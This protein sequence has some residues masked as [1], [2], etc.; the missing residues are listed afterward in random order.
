MQRIPT[1]ALYRLGA[2][3]VSQTP[4]EHSEQ[5]PEQQRCMQHTLH[6]RL[7]RDHLY[8]RDTEQARVAHSAPLRPPAS[9]SRARDRA[10]IAKP[11]AS[12]AATQ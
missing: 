2:E 3:S 12:A 6:G 11:N 8:M 4:G 7:H 5:D 10:T 9:Y 1:T